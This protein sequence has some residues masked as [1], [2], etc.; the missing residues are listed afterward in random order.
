MTCEDKRPTVIKLPCGATILVD[1]VPHK[2]SVAIGI[3]SRHGSRDE[4]VPGVTHF[5]E[6]M[7]F[8]GTKNKSTKEILTAIED[9][10]GYVDADTTHDYISIYARCLT[11]NFS[12]MMSLIGEMVSSPKFDNSDV[13]TERLVILEEYKSFL[14][15]PDDFV[16][17]LLYEGLFPNHP[18]GREILGTWESICSITQEDIIR[19]WKE[20]Y[21]RESLILSVSGTIEPETVVNAFEKSFALP[22]QN[23]KVM[24]ESQF[25]P[26]LEGKFHLKTGLFQTQLTLGRRIPDY[27]DR[28]RPAFIV[29]N[30]ILGSGM[31]SRLSIRLREELGLVYTFSTFLEYMRGVGVIG[32]HTVFDPK[33]FE[34]TLNV[35]RDEFQKIKN[36]GIT[37]V[38]FN[39]AIR[40]IKGNLLIS[41]ESLSNRMVSQAVEHIHTGRVNSLLEHLR[42]FENLKIEDVGEVLQRYLDLENWTHGIV[43][44]KELPLGV[45]KGG[46]AWKAMASQNY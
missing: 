44:P 1:N 7:L 26:T 42:M 33:N 39:R 10:G 35:I 19:R 17:Y 28:T 45:L 11:E 21:S 40:R 22:R 37:E 23:A 13:E 2:N 46:K 6:H 16:F 9:M 4:S 32:L 3:F 8:K 24:E 12:E 27:A 18:L 34:A 31:S 36:E 43:S 29:L 41:R 38:E 30:S 20:V 25:P 14:E 5:L 15:T